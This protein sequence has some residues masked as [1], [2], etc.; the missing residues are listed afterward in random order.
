MSGS[1]DVI[2]LGGGAW[3]SAA[4]QPLA[5]RSRRV[6]C[7]D[8]FTPP[9]SNGSTHGHSRLINTN[10]ESS[11][12]NLALI[13]RS[14]ELWRELE[15]LSGREL[16]AQVGYLFVGSEGSTR[17]ARSL[18]SLGSEPVSYEVLSATDIARRFPQ[19]R[20]S[21]DEIGIFDPEAARLDP[22]TCVT[23]ALDVATRSGAA[24][25]FGEPVVDWTSDAHGVQVVTAVGTY[26]AE[27]LV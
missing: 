3:G 16:L 5:T 8:R 14:Y 12:R 4:T 9:H 22:E 23:A 19:F 11:S 6:L 1:D 15:G 17:M 18:S 20:V 10:A 24:L 13:K 2:V 27:K 21:S 25:R 26:T 7:I